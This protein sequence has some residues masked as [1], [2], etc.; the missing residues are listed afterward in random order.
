MDKRIFTGALHHQLPAKFK[1]RFAVT[2]NLLHVAWNAAFTVY[3]SSP[4][5]TYC[6]IIFVS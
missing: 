5:S 4:A 1:Y 6:I 2:I 3:L